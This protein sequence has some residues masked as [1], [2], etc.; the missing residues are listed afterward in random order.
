MFAQLEIF[1]T[2]AQMADHAAARQAVI[3]T[4]I[5]HA[6]TPGFAALDILP[7][8]DVYA[9]AGDGAMRA[10]RPGHHL[11]AGHNGDFEVFESVNA[12]TAPNGNSVSLEHQMMQAAET[13]VQHDMALGVYKS[14]LSILRQAFSG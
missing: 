3:S 7:F 14:A 11:G 5:A 6:D 13:R 10:T 1:Q 8:S 9:S 4:N 2:A 12:Q